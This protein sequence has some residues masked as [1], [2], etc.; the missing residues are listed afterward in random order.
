MKKKLISNLDATF[1]E[2]SLKDDGLMEEWLNFG[3]NINARDCNGMTAL[4]I[5]SCNGEYKVAKKLIEKGAS[6]NI[7]NEI[8]KKTALIYA[9]EF[10]N[11]EI[12]NLLLSCGASV[13]VKSTLGDIP[14]MMAACRGRVDIME[15]LVKYW[16]DVNTQ[17]SGGKTV[18]MYAVLSNSDAVEYLL[19]QGADID[20]QDNDG[21]T[22]LMIAATAPQCGT[23]T[24]L[25][26]YGADVN[27]K[28]KKGKSALDYANKADV[29]N[30]LIKYVVN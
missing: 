23:L 29:R 11:I 26:E 13:R 30:L 14:I 12:V 3:A 2:S 27:I 5:A 24:K 25:L 18:L 22:A 9:I 19:N 28:N 16:A 8:N 15:S 6:V 1:I 20:K 7:I 4:M 17:D 10:E 21:N